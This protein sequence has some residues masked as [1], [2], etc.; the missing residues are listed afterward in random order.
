[1]MQAKLIHAVTLL[2]GPIVMLPVSSQAAAGVI[3]GTFNIDGI[4]IAKIRRCMPNAASP[5]KLSHTR[6]VG[7]P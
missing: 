7:W 6:K 5:L 4:A 3:H 1:M 2:A